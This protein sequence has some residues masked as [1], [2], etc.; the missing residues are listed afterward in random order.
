MR[1]VETQDKV[2]LKEEGIGRVG[3][4]SLQHKVPDEMRIIIND[5]P[6][7]SHKYK[8]LTNRNNRSNHRV[9]ES[10]VGKGSKSANL[11]SQL[12]DGHGEAT[13]SKQLRTVMIFSS[14]LQYQMYQ[15]AHAQTD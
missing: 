12:I 10:L 4:R 6:S 1:Q 14:H 8:S 5:R 13:E 2:L 11:S 7:H 9:I 15:I 3:N